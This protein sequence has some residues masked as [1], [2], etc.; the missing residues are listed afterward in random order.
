[1]E[2]RARAYHALTECGYVYLDNFY[3]ADRVHAFRKLRHR[4]H[5][6]S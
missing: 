2:T 3:P 6:T 5:P 1:M 4:M